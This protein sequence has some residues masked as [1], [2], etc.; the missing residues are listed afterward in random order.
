MVNPWCVSGEYSE[1]YIYTGEGECVDI[2]C[3]WGFCEVDEELVGQSLATI[4][5]YAVL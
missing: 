3:L 5:L 4:L 2:T 1:E